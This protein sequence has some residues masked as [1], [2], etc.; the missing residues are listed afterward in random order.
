M[1]THPSVDVLLG[2]LR[3]VLPEDLRNVLLGCLRNV[4]RNCLRNALPGNLGNALPGNL[5]N[6]LPV[7]L[8]N[9]LP[10]NLRNARGPAVEPHIEVRGYA[11]AIVAVRFCASLTDR[12]RAKQSRL[13]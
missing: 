6:V 13:V 1:R 10:G 5:R 12:Y 7:D 4:L 3:N 8:G 11:K 9:A 2:C